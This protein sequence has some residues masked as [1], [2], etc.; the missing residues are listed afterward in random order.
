MGLY[1]TYTSPVRGGRMG[2][3]ATHRRRASREHAPPV[4]NSLYKRIM[5]LKYG[6]NA[7]HKLV[8]TRPARAISD[9]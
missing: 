8:I 5:P 9:L 3:L 7:V 1:I 4:V 6:F 2:A